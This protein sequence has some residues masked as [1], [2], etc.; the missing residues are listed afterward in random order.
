MQQA[1]QK[2]QVGDV[3]DILREYFHKFFERDLT[4]SRY[5][6]KHFQLLG[7]HKLNDLMVI[8]VDKTRQEVTEFIGRLDVPIQMSLKCHLQCVIVLNDWLRTCLRIF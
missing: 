8:C 4:G 2:R 3:V 6:F 5:Q 7:F 1:V